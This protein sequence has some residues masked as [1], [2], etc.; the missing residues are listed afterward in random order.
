MARV[1]PEATC[2]ELVPVRRVL[3]KLK[4]LDVSDSFEHKGGGPDEQP[5]HVD[6]TSEQRRRVFHRGDEDDRHLNQHYP[7][8]LDCPSAE[9]PE[10]YLLHLV[11]ARVAPV[12]QDSQVEKG[13][14]PDH[15]HRRQQSEDH[16]LRAGAARAVD[17]AGDNYRKVCQAARKV[18]VLF[19]PLGQAVE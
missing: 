13:S 2:D 17:E 14:K 1:P 11:E 8:C 19:A 18:V 7:H 12:A 10:R 9:E 4:L 5:H 16:L 6:A 3:A 15:P